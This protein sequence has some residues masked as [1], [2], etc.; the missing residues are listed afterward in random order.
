MFTIGHI[1]K[2]TNVSVET[3]RYYE[4][5]GLLPDPK[6][7]PFSG[8]RL[9]DEDAISRLRF[10]KRAQE[11]G[12]SLTEIRELLFLTACND[13]KER[14]IQKINELNGKIKTLQKMKRALERLVKTCK[15]KGYRNE[16]PIVDALGK[17]E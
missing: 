3:I 8:Y 9:Y 16:C 11:L 13:V 6:R 14:S 5:R 2:R 10:I 12:F 7:R 4:Q 1:A 17:D 15:N